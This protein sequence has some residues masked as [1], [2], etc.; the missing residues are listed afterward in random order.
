MRDSL[1]INKTV[2][3]QKIYKEYWRSMYAYAFNILRDKQVAEDIIQEIFVDVWGR[4][5]EAEIENMK[6]YLFQAVR[7]QCA[8]VFKTGNLL[9]AFQTEQLEMAVELIAEESESPHFKEELAE[10][11]LQK[12]TEVLSGQCYNVFELRFNQHLTIKEI[13]HKLEISGS[14]VENHINKALKI[15]RKEE[16]YEI[17]LVAFLI[18][19]TLSI[20]V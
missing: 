11:I 4:L 5:D 18:V 17:R 13:A 12:A 20:V 6:S 15:L 3:F 7:Y 19:S 2:E 10:Q 16:L 1:H 14:T 9:G 8:K